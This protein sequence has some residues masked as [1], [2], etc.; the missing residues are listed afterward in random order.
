MIT[1]HHLTTDRRKHAHALLLALFGG[2]AILAIAPFVATQEPDGFVN[3]GEGT[4]DGGD[5]PVVGSLPCAVDPTLD[6]KFYQ[7]A[8]NA[9]A[10]VPVPVMG[11][12]GASLDTQILDALGTPTGF[13]NRSGGYTIFGMVQNGTAIVSRANLRNG[14]IDL[15][16]WVPDSFLGGCVTSLGSLGSGKIDITGNVVT[17]PIMGVAASPLLTA[18]VWYVIAP[19]PAQSGQSVPPLRVHVVIA[20]GL[21]TISYLP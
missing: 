8:N 3:S 10:G 2:L 20:N 5:N 4:S 21:A 9:H 7:S 19:P 17:L 16:Q 11:L 18:D 14:V 15:A 12:I 6:L 1:S 13:V